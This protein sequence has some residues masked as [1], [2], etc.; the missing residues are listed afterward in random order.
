MA[1][2]GHLLQDQDRMRLTLGERRVH[3]HDARQAVQTGTPAQQV[4]AGA[5]RGALLPAPRSL[6]PDRNVQARD[7]ERERE[8]RAEEHAG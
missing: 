2:V 5:A 7:E 4:D 1:G 8:A 3:V 6:R